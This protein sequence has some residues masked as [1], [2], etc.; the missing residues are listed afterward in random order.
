MER[1][2]A[3][4]SRFPLTCDDNIEHPPACEEDDWT[5]FIS[6]PVS[7]RFRA[8]LSGF[9]PQHFFIPSRCLF[10]PVR[11]EGGEGD[12]PASAARSSNG[13]GSHTKSNRRSF[14]CASRGEAA[15]GSA[16]DGKR[17]GHPKCQSSP[18]SVELRSR[19]NTVFRSSR[20]HLINTIQS[21]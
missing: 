2:E 5:I 4:A 16:Q 10:L 11:D 20:G 1:V 9:D 17:M 14:D 15:R 7:G 3:Y 21:L 13:W 19:I 18:M 8:L 12:S 6:P